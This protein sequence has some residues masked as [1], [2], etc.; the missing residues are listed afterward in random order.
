MKF[1]NFRLI[2]EID[3]RKNLMPMAVALVDVT[4]GVLWFKRTHTRSVF[5]NPVSWQWAGTGKYV[6]SQ[7][8]NCLAEAYEAEQ[9]IAKS[10]AAALI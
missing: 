10:A 2:K 8:L 3:T 9:L 6:L 7:Q 1:S 4:T 5:R